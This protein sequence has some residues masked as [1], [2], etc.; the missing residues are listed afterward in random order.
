MARCSGKETG[1][2][3]ALTTTVLGMWGH[4]VSGT[5]QRSLAMRTVG[6][7]SRWKL[8]VQTGSWHRRELSLGSRGLRANIPADPLRELSR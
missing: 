6:I 8:I 4:A 7:S 5:M 2:S 3:G 1:A